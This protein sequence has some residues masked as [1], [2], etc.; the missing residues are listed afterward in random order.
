MRAIDLVADLG[1]V[2]AA[3][4]AKV[5]DLPPLRIGL[6]APLSEAN[7][8][9]LSFSDI[10]R[11]EPARKDWLRSNCDEPLTNVLF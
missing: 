3:E 11:F 7:R 5:L 9:L 10:S 8:H 2:V 1:R 4:R 6:Q